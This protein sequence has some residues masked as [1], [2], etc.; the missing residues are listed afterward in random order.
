M[1]FISQ[2]QIPRLSDSAAGQGRARVCRRPLSRGGT[3]W[4]A[5]GR[6]SGRLLGLADRHPLAVAEAFSGQDGLEGPGGNRACRFLRL[7]GG[8]QRWRATPR[9]AAAQP[10]AAV[11]FA[12]AGRPAMH[13]CC[14]LL[15]MIS[16]RL[17]GTSGHTRRLPGGLSGLSGKVGSPAGRDFPCPLGG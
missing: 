8:A 15:P 3:V 14:E 1:F 17:A 2:H 11:R 5:R 9:E 12:C 16:R 6:W 7:A 4:T 13:G 10:A